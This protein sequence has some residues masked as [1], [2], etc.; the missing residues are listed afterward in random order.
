MKIQPTDYEKIRL[1]VQTAMAECPPQG[2]RSDRR[3]RWD[4][5]N[6]AQDMGYIDIHGR[7]LR[8]YDYLND[9]HIDTALK[10]IVA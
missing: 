8:L 5:L 2:D 7:G 9:S 3:Y 4:L 10:R 6:Y 1:A